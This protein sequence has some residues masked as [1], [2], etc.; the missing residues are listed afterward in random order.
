MQEVHFTFS[1][2]MVPIL[3]EI[4]HGNPLKALDS[5]LSLLNPTSSQGTR[6][7]VLQ[8]ICVAALA[9]Q[10]QLAVDNEDVLNLIFHPEL[11]LSQKRFVAL[12]LLRSLA[13]HPDVFLEPVLRNRAFL[14]FDATLSD[15]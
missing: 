5:A 12:C 8:M 2:A 10:G 4:E 7:L 13:T 9:A 1:N 3:H 15:I 14:L 6:L 11:P